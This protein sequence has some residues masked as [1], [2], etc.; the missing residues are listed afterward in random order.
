MGLIATQF[1]DG[2]VGPLALLSGGVSG[3]GFL[4]CAHQ[5]FGQSGAAAVAHM[6]FPDQGSAYLARVHHIR[7]IGN[8]NPALPNKPGDL[9]D[10]NLCGIGQLLNVGLPVLTQIFDADLILGFQ[11][12]YARLAE[13]HKPPHIQPPASWT[14][15]EIHNSGRRP[16][17]SKI[18]SDCTF[19]ASRLHDYRLFVYYSYRL[20]TIFM[21]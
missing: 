16:F 1:I 14:V 19:Y 13:L 2:P 8:G 11:F 10:R 9:L 21:L 17:L 12:F 6:P 20:F 3:S 5:I 4:G 7:R 18:A 15:I